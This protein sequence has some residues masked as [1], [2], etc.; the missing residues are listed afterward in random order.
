MR[1][2]KEPPPSSGGRNWR[3][4]NMV[5]EQ[6]SMPHDSSAEPGCQQGAVAFK[7]EGSSVPESQFTIDTAPQAVTT[8]QQSPFSD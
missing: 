2:E 7:E 1:P 5:F 4:F 8:V 3:G 6:G